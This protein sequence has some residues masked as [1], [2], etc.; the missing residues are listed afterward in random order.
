MRHLKPMSRLH[1][2]PA[3]AESI[4]IKQAQLEL[5]AQAVA[6]LGEIIALFNP[7]ADGGGT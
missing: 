5:I 6:V 2:A 3:K 4:L 7:P 1:P